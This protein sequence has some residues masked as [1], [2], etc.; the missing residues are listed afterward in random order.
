[1]KVFHT[2]YDGWYITKDAKGKI[3]A[4]EGYALCPTSVQ[5]IIDKTKVTTL[6][7]FAR[8][9]ITYGYI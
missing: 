5:K 8:E 3:K 2:T 6:D 9:A 4:Y 7:C 1:M